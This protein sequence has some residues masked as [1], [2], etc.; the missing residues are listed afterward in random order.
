MAVPTSQD[1]KA[2]LIAFAAVDRG[3]FISYDTMI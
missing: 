1:S 3:T 2:L